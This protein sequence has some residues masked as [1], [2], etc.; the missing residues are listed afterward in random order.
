MLTNKPYKLASKDFK[1]KTVVKVNGVEIGGKDFTVI[2]G[3]CAV[4][5][6][7]Q[8]ITTALKVKECG[9]Q[10]LRSSLFKPRTSPYSFQG[11]GI[12]GLKLLKQAKQET[13]LLIETEVMDAK[14]IPLVSEYVDIFRIGSRNMQNFN[15]LK[16]VGKTDKP[17]ILKRGMSATIHEWL[18][19]A[20]YIMSEG[21][22]KVILCERGIR[23]FES[24]TRNTLDISAIPVV[25]AESHLPII[26][27]P[28]HSTGNRAYVVPMARA[29]VAAGADGIIVEVHPDPE[30]AL[31]DGFQSLTFQQFEEMM[32]SVRIIEKVIKGE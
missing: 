13:G 3:P 17:V 21:N 30:N 18:L 4:E 29:A 32:N 28:S 27:D 14:T 8:F 25:H 20:E 23:T 6:E 1:E 10:I 7:K 16:E 9:A 2:A 22:H 24:A 31:S 11:L 26:I 5:N 15:L 12:E 19:A